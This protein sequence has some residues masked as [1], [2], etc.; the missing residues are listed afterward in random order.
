[1]SRDPAKRHG[2]ASA[3]GGDE[4]DALP[5]EL[6]HALE[7][8]W[9]GD[10]AKLDHLL[11]TTVSGRGDESTIAR[12]VR[13]AAS[14]NSHVEAGDAPSDIADF[15][16]EGEL[17]RGGMGVVY[18]ARQRYPERTVA[19][20]L[21]RPG[22]LTA[23]HR[24]RFRYEADVL[25]SLSHPNIATIHQAGIYRIGEEDQPY[26]VMELVAGEPLTTFV[27]RRRLAMDERLSLF[28]QV[29]GAAH[30][31]HQRGVIHRDLKPE[32]VL[33]SE[34][35]ELGNPPVVKLLDFG[36]ARPIDG[37]D[38]SERPPTADSSFIGTMLYMSP[39]Q[40]DGKPLD[41]RSDV[42]SLGVML[43][44]L[45]MARSPYERGASSPA[46]VMGAIRERDP[47]FDAAAGVPEDLQLIVRTAMTKDVGQRYSSADA[48]AADVGRFLRH[49]PIMAR[50][51]SAAY[52]FRKFARRNPFI[53]AAAVVFATFLV[54]AFTVVSWLYMEARSARLAEEQQRRVAERE[55]V[56]Q[57]AVRDFLQ[58]MLDVA[59]PR[60]GTG[61]RDVTV[62]DVIDRA[63][64]SLNMGEV[65]YEPEVEALV[66]DLIADVY[67]AFARFEDAEQM[68]LAARRL[69]REHLQPDHLD[70]ALTAHNLGSLYYRIGDLD[71]AQP[72]LE[73]ALD[74]RRA[75]AG[76]TSEAFATTLNNLGQVM[77]QRGEHQRAHEMQRRVLQI[78]R[79]VLEDDHPLIGQALNN[80]AVTSFHLGRADDA[81]RT[82][83]EALT[84]RE[85]V[86]GE[87]HPEVAE[88]LSNL[89]ILKERR[90]AFDEAE[91]D[92][93]RSIAIVRE[94]F[95]DENPAVQSPLNNLA[96]LMYA[97][98]EFEDAAE[99]MQEVLRIAEFNFDAAHP[100]VITTRNNLAVIFS[101]LDRLDEAEAM[102]REVL[103]TRLETLPGDHPDVALSHGTLGQLLGR[104]G[105]VDGAERHLRRSLE[106]R[107]AV[108]GQAHPD[109]LLAS[110]ALAEL[111]AENERF[112]EAESILLDAR[113]AINEAEQIPSS[114]IEA[115]EQRLASLHE[116]SEQS[117]Q[118]DA[119]IEEADLDS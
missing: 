16:I 38:A 23:E 87:S 61:D 40:V 91:A 25:A 39:E 50:R 71:R 79:A 76:E 1:M 108:L 104:Q 84:L 118:S 67:V 7:A 82:Y 2:Q 20:K 37:F 24:R 8:M 57:Q 97:R 33:V 43:Y 112:D 4:D 105:D 102:M 75:G 45:L 5:D 74:L 21:I 46:E 85:R 114:T 6:D 53:V 49:E 77:T 42:Y 83:T 92:L 18:R 100:S 110:T 95:G 88:T 109:A 12:M 51:P 119:A 19:I 29:C 3:R 99:L 101:R 36:V 55:V 31:A 80:M 81:E 52:Q 69:R 10:G 96:T 11:R 86:F 62:R 98:G 48:L 56:K 15:T 72:L 66:R 44:E 68:Y 13:A 89:A 94:S 32:N 93:R 59:D 70:H 9:H 90:G 117:G 113:A 30:Y 103:A 28:T 27:H 73:E 17:G 26:I 116:Q 14:L 65:R 58:D 41:V 115:I 64:A 35:T 63:A 54:T 22:K 106:I 78:R 111:L 107:R 34:P 47:H 60:I